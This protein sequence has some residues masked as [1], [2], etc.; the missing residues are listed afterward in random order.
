M[1]PIHT[2][3]QLLKAVALVSAG[4]SAIIGVAAVI[5]AFKLL[6]LLKKDRGGPSRAEA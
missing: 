2:T 5:I 3:E 6:A 4:L 1:F